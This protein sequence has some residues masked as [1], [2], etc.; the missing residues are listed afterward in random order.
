MSAPLSPSQFGAT[1]EPTPYTVITQ[2]GTERK[3]RR[4]RFPTAEAADRYAEA[5]TPDTDGQMVPNVDE[6]FA[7]HPHY[8]RSHFWHGNRYAVVH[9]KGEARYE[10]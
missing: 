4:K 2:H 9:L 7:K 3:T 5:N 1:K 10:S 6:K 8:D